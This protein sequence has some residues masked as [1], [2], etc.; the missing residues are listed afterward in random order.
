MMIS[1]F[2]IWNPSPDQIK[3]VQLKC[4]GAKLPGHLSKFP[5]QSPQSIR[6]L[7]TDG[8]ETFLVDHYQFF[9]ADYFSCI[10]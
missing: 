2:S 9:C 5:L 6:K 7:S 10:D 3:I 1:V 4:P 8:C